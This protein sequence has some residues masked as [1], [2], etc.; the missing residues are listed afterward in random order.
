MAPPSPRVERHVTASKTRLWPGRGPLGYASSFPMRFVALVLAAVSL[1]LAA[2]TPPPPPPRREICGNGLDDNGDGKADCLDPT[3]FAE[4]ICQ[5]P[6]ENCTNQVDDDRNGLADCMDPACAGEVA[7]LRIENCDNGQD[8]NGNGR[9]DCADGDC[10]GKPGCGD[11]GAEAPASCFDTLDNDNNGFKDCR[12]PACLGRS[13]G[14]GCACTDAGV[15]GEADCGN[16]MDDDGDGRADCLDTECEQASCGPGCA[17]VGGNRGE[18]ECG[19]GL[20]NDADTQRDCADSDCAMRTC[21]A[22]CTC[23]M[24]AKVETSCADAMDNDADGDVDCADVDC[25]NVSC[26]AGCVCLSRRKTENACTDRMDNDGDGASDCL[27]TPDC[28][29][30]ACGTG[31]TCAGGR[32]RETSCTD[33]QDNDSDGLRDCADTMDCM[34]AVNRCGSPPSPESMACSDGFDNDNNGFI[35]CE[36]TGCAN[37]AC[38]GGCTCRNGAQAETNCSDGIDNDF[39]TRTD[40]AD[41]DCMGLGT[42]T[43]CTDGRDNDCNGSIDCGDMGCVAN[44]ACSNLAA[45]SACINSTQCAAGTCQDEA[46]SGWPGG[47]C[48]GGV[49]ACSRNDAGVSTGCPTNTVCVHDQHGRFCRQRCS[50]TG[51]CRTGY[52]CH[53]EDEDSDSPNWCAPLCTSDADCRALGGTYGC[54]P[55]SKLCQQKD[56]TRQKYGGACTANTECETGRCLRQSS[57]GGYCEGLCLRNGGTCGGDGVC[58]PTASG[59]ATG[60]C[61][62]GCTMSGTNTECRA[63]S[64]QRCGPA[65]TGSV[66]ACYCRV[67]GE[68]CQTSDQCCR[69]T[70]FPVGGCVVVFGFGSCAQ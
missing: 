53:D 34:G 24:G 49:N 55:W 38:G 8:D 11:G 39:D 9:L 16:T 28:D 12:D 13:C 69:P 17:C 42:E 48:V 31:C 63:G 68:R 51:G 56:R 18:G 30:T 46:S 60:R 25:T 61:L 70:G 67:A 37:Q 4:S 22:G 54:N 59:D 32:R 21:G 43:S 33:K 65:P 19:D 57:N 41:S 66:N 40:C 45:G 14:T 27:D 10:Q 2:C 7:C 35:D 62:D 64:P 58:E 29:G 36:D 26:G 44:A 47:A 23:R 1:W 6:L 20:D 5:V 52:A 3:C 50:G 15:R